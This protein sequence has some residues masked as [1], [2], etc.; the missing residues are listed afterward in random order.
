MWAVSHV[1]KVRKAIPFFIFHHPLKNSFIF[2]EHTFML[3]ENRPTRDA[4]KRKTPL[5]FGHNTW[6]NKPLSKHLSP[7]IA[8]LACPFLRVE[9]HFGKFC[10]SNKEN[11][12]ILVIYLTL[13]KHH[14]TVPTAA[15]R[16]EQRLPLQGI[17][18]HGH[19]TA[20]SHSLVML[21]CSRSVSADTSFL[22]QR[23]LFMFYICTAAST[24]H[25]LPFSIST[26]QVLR[27]YCILHICLY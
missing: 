23:M 7:P 9:S 11:K 4:L 24:M 26:T 10:S 16:V 22:E 12:P 19:A 20:Q 14:L 3:L 18:L 17:L 13:I 1:F 25:L 2:P 6:A 21:P 5:H 8:F 27:R 15:A